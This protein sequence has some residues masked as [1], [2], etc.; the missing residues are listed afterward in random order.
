MPASVYVVRFIDTHA[1]NTGIFDR[2]DVNKE[3]D[4]NSFFRLIIGANGAYSSSMLLWG[5]WAE[6]I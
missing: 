4:K 3:A 2:T 1:L 6:V 5:P